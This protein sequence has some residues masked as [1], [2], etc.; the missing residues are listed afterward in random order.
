MKNLSMFHQ[1]REQ[2]SETR[3]KDGQEE[4][5]LAIL[6][7]IM[8]KNKVLEEMEAKVGRLEGGEDPVQ[9]ALVKKLEQLEALVNQKSVQRKEARQVSQKMDQMVDMMMYQMSNM[10]QMM[11]GVAQ[12]QKLQYQQALETNKV[13]NSLPQL[14]AHS[15]FTRLPEINKKKM[16]DSTQR[17]SVATTKNQAN[18]SRKQPVRAIYNADGN[19]RESTKDLKRRNQKGGRSSSSSNYSSESPRRKTGAMSG[20]KGGQTGAK[21]LGPIKVIDSRN[22]LISSAKNPKVVDSNNFRSKQLS[23]MNIA[24]PQGGAVSNTQNNPDK[25]DRSGEDSSEF[26]YTNKD[27]ESINF[28]TGGLKDK[29]EIMSERGMGG[30]GNERSRRNKDLSKT[31][32]L[33]NEDSREK[34][35]I[36]G[37]QPLLEGLNRPKARYPGPGGEDRVVTNQN[38]PTGDL[39]PVLNQ[40]NMKPQSWKGQS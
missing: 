12:M 15:N 9:E 36:Q 21:D 20:G 2:T 40:P 17:I 39:R 31:K 3:A 10:Q 13:L 11:T 19:N 22:N 1:M 7:S 16:T 4:F 27:G 38:S 29:T 8:E 23:K 6:K 33:I 14:L 5:K 18:P 37:N 34:V 30:D 25:E 24:S 28:G 26:N 32:S 35:V